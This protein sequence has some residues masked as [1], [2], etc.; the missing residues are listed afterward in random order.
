MSF[1]VGGKIALVTGA[2]RGI[3]RAIVEACLDH[4]A[5]KVYAAVR[6]VRSAGDLVTQHGERVVPIAIEISDPET[7]RAAADRVRD[8]HLVVNNAGVLQMGTPLDSN[9]IA[10]LRW[11]IEVN[12]Y[13]LVRMARAFAPALAANGGGAFVQLNSLASFKSFPQLG[14][15]SASKAAAYSITLALRDQL[16][17]QGTQVVGV[18]P[19]PI[20]TDMLTA[21]GY[22][23]GEPPAIVA[24]AILAA[25]A[26]G[27]FRVFPDTLAKDYGTAYESF[28]RAIV[29]A[30]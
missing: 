6:D 23:G 28:A 22:T 18:F 9:A 3:G 1:D 11:H 4:G 13:G 25:L 19:G 30:P 7:I 27:D 24:E 29:D 21:A 15:Y 5:A 20:A 2:N 14:L 16:A 10:A 17:E 26:A 8:V 12:V